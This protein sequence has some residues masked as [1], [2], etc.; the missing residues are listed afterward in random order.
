MESSTGLGENYRKVGQDLQNR[1][2]QLQDLT[3]EAP[4]QIRQL[5][6][7]GDYFI[8]IGDEIDGGASHGIDFTSSPGLNVTNVQQ[9]LTWKVPSPL[10][11]ANTASIASGTT[12]DV[13][14]WASLKLIDFKIIITILPAY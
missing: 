12:G 5:K 14:E 7:Y 9:A 13:A 4:Q 11:I 10:Q 1:A 3:A 8:Y 2:G 6:A